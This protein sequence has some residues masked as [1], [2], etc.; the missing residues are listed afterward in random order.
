MPSEQDEQ[1]EGVPEVSS[2]GQK[3]RYVGTPGGGGGEDRAITKSAMDK[4]IRVAQ[5]AAIQNQRNIRQAERYVRQWVGDMAFDSARDHFD[6]YR[7]TLQALDVKGIDKVHRDA[8]RPIL[9]A[10]P[11]LGQRMQH[12]QQ[13]MRMAADSA[14]A[15]G[16]F[17]DRF[18]DAMKIT[19][20]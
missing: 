11:R 17:A 7:A 12:R 9:E 4:A 1:I 10:Q 3:S 8:L 6:V 20:Q 13:Q 14:P 15:Q 18:P 2:K 16:S 5:D 19:I